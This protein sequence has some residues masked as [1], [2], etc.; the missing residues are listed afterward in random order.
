[1][2]YCKHTEQRPPDSGG[3]AKWPLISSFRGRGEYQ[4]PRFM[5]APDCSDEQSRDGGNCSESEFDVES[6]AL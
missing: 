3:F 6:S 5:E 1:M 2:L 4:S